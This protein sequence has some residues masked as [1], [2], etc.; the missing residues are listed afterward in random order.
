MPSQVLREQSLG[1]RSFVALLRGYR[2]ARRHLDA[3]LLAEHG[4]TGADYDVLL[5]LAWAPN[6][7]M[8][9]ID[10]ADEVLLTASGVTRLLDGLEREGLVERSACDTDRRVVY[11][12][13]T[14]DGLAKLRE[15]SH[16]HVA[17]VEMYF[18]ARF[19]EEELTD[20]AGLLGR[21]GADEPQPCDLP[22]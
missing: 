16:S 6:R 4:L 18:T 9:R 20:L 1:V 7:R 21:L 5:H 19:G 14:D 22:D 3:Q 13:L 8:R 11:A 2:N 15:A 12:V 17:Q 10:L